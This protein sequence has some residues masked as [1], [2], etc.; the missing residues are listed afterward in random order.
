MPEHY[1][2]GQFRLALWAGLGTAL[3]RLP[4][5]P[6]KLASGLW[7]AQGACSHAGR[8]QTTP[9]GGWTVQKRLYLSS[10][11][12]LLATHANFQPLWHHPFPLAS[13][14]TLR[15]YTCYFLTSKPLF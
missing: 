2:K 1:T 12:I 10:G 15:V 9:T 7:P 4:C 13:D 14:Y 11:Q 8:P 3:G 5:G 6:P